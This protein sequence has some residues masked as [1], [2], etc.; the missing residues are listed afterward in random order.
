MARNISVTVKPNARSAAITKLT[1]T[2]YRASVH[3]PAEDGK[4]KFRAH[5]TVRRLFL[6]S[7]VHGYDRSRALRAKKIT[8]NR[9]MMV[10]EIERLNNSAISLKFESVISLGQVGSINELRAREKPHMHLG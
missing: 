8:Q 2:E 4:A 5:R 7:Q 1:D 9:S 3:A 10:D 6:R